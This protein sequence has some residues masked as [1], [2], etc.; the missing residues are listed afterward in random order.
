MNGKQKL[1]CAVFEEIVD[2]VQN[3]LSKTNYF[4][5]SHK[6]VNVAALKYTPSTKLDNRTIG[7]KHVVLVL[8][9]TNVI[10]SNGLLINS[11][12]ESKSAEGKEKC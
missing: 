4:T 8:S 7:Q 9:W 11:D 1:E 10:V 6:E 12:F 2:A 3:K 5:R